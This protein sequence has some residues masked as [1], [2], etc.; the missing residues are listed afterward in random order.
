MALATSGILSVIAFR[1]I[2]S[3][4]ISGLITN[5]L[6]DEVYLRPQHGSHPTPPAGCD[7]T[8]VTTQTLCRLRRCTV[9]LAAFSSHL[10]T[11]LTAH[12]QPT[13][14]NHTILTLTAPLK[15]PHVCLLQETC[16]CIRPTTV[17]Q[18]A[19]PLFPLSSLRDCLA[20]AAG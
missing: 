16:S 9:V 4:C 13:N 1:P 17:E 7:Q 15:R 18:I 11:A 10:V 14:S 20:A 2:P 8:L 3:T 6:H 5:S 19:D 12:A